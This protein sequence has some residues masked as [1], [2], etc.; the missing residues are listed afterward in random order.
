RIRNHTLDHLQEYV[1]ELI[2][3]FEKNGGKTHF[4]KNG[5]EAVKA[6]LSIAR[7][8]QAKRIVKS[9]S[10]VTEEI[11]LNHAL[12]EDGINVVE[13]DLGEF[14]I[15]L[16]GETPSHILAP[17]I[18]KSR[19][20]VAELFSREAGRPLTDRT[21]DLTRYARE[22]LRQEFLDADLG[23]TGCNF[24]VAESGS[25]ILISNEGNARMASSLPK[26]HIVVM[27]MERI[28]PTWAEL[29]VLVTM[30]TRN[31][32]G[33]KLSVYM[34]AISG[35]RRVGDLDGPEEVHLIILD[36]GRS[37]IL[38]SNYRE[39]LKCIRCSACVNVC[40]V[41]REIGGH[42]Y[43][44][45]YSGP[46][47]AVLTPLLDGMEKNKELPFASSL[48]GACTEVCP[49]KIPLHH[50]L[51]EER[52]DMVEKGFLPKQERVTFQAFAFLTAHPLF[53][54]GAARGA[55]RLSP[56]FG[57]GGILKKGPGMLAGWTD[58]RD[59]PLPAKESFHDWWR[60]QRGEK[61]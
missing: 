4:A 13:T 26:V 18:H 45:V 32:T 34:T 1:N 51:I 43:G 7:K 50:Y 15:Q 55:G 39:V 56:M 31:A 53:Y 37:D 11:H 2:T 24:A 33:Q 60:R 52:K 16:A 12:E 57:R 30:L 38:E 25:I 44:G 10:M 46:I 28:V 3:N 54:R 23:I 42:A 9:K 61:R 17:A 59:L 19:Q 36:N 6:V 35:P 14:I 41:Y 47:G 8:H 20:E 48:C 58:S 49:V 22:R 21:E 40:P 5:E 29:D 27:G